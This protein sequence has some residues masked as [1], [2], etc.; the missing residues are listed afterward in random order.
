MVFS[1]LYWGDELLG[2][3]TEAACPSHHIRSGG[4]VVTM[5]RHCGCWP[6]SHGWGCVCPVSPL[7]GYCPCLPICTLWNHIAMCSPHIRS[8]N[9]WYRFIYEF[10]HWFLSV[11][12]ICSFFSF[13]SVSVRFWYQ[14]VV[15]FIK[16]TWNV[17]S[18]Y[19]LSVSAMIH[20][21]SVW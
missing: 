19:T 21:I 6:W 5:T 9:I 16:R 3:T 17:S 4:P 1:W 11:R 12:L 15:L 10:L 13:Y 14:C 7:Y 2:K 8:R 20:S 18:F